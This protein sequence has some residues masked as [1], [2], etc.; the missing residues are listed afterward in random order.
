MKGKMMDAVSVVSRAEKAPAEKISKI[1][2]VAV[3]S[4]AC[5]M[6]E[7]ITGRG[8]SKN[9]TPVYL[10]SDDDSFFKGA[11]GLHMGMDRD[12]IMDDP[13]PMVSLDHI[14]STVDAVS[15]KLSG[16]DTNC[17]PVTATPPA[18][19]PFFNSF[20]GRPRT[21]KTAQQCR[22]PV[23]FYSASACGAVK[24]PSPGWKNLYGS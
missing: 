23:T 24:A 6:V 2:V 4:G 12:S 22:D 10:T 3:G 9:V 17:S 13:H 20:P 8:M 21:H 18:V 16:A 5:R 1:Q 14:E 15:E 7:R 11:N 19:L